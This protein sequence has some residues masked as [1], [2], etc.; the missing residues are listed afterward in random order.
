MGTSHSTVNYKITDAAKSAFSEFVKE[1][2]ETDDNNF[3]EKNLLRSA[4]RKY[5]YIKNIPLTPDEEA[6]IIAL[7]IL[8]GY[9]RGG[10]EN[11]DVIIGLKL[12]KWPTPHKFWFQSKQTNNIITYK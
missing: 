1:Y 6:N 2:C 5:A 8:C 10:D 9:Q 7:A 12:I 3:T 4:W 11:V